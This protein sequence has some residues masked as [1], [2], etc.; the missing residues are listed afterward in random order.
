MLGR[1][2]NLLLSV[3]RALGDAGFNATVAGAGPGKLVRLSRHCARYEQVA[4][5]EA[6]LA[7]PAGGVLSAIETL[8]R[9]SGAELV[10][11]ADVAGALCAARLRARL[12]SLKYFPFSEPETLRTLND[13]WTFYGFLQRHGL[14]SP[15]SWLIES[16]AQASALALPL[17]IKPLADAGGRGITVVGDAAARDAR[18]TG[19][20]SLPAL[21]QEFI[22][23]VEVSMSFLADRGRLLG[24]AIHLR[25]PDGTIE[26]V[27][28]PRV[29]DLGRR[30]AA[31]ASYTGPANVDMRYDDRDPASVTVIEC[32]PRFWGSFDYT[33]GLGAD[34]LGRGL[35][36]A[37]GKMPE[38]M[39]RT[40]TGA[41]PGILGSLRRFADGDFTVTPGTRAVLSRKLGDPVPEL[42]KAALHVLGRSIEGP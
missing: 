8:A 25:R 21:A 37:D 26:Y 38:T 41:C 30:I 31:A 34:F 15:R 27:D 28:D 3:V 6:G 2:E 32:N 23:G 22:P 35:A 4:A 12:P 14:P 13:K 10:V 7:E 11:A 16:A 33:V 29:V 9:E 18:L 19:E 5:S 24:W 36:L 42:Y 20:G 17:I 39:E 1:L 40:P